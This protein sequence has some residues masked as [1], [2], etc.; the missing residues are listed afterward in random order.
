MRWFL[1]GGQRHQLLVARQV[2]PLHQPNTTNFR[3]FDNQTLTLLRN[4]E[5]TTNL[6]EMFLFCPH[7]QQTKQEHLR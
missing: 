2:S 7:G 4:A 5:V 1:S 3:Q 6:I